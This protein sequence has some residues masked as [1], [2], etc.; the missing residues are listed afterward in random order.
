MTTTGPAIFFDGITSARHDVTVELAAAALI[1]RAADG[2]ALAQWPYNEIEPLSAPAGLLRIGR[3][4]ST[5]LARLDVIDQDLA[6]AIDQR[7]VPIDR[8]GAAERRGRRKV[9]F[10]SVAATASL[11]VMAIFGVPELATRLA[12]HIPLGVERR[13]GAAVDTQIRSM[14]D[15]KKA[16]ARFE[17]GNNDTEKAAR[18]AFE[19]LAGTLIVEADLAIPIRIAVLRKS[20]ANAITLPGGIVYVF[21]GLIDKSDTPDELAGV[22]AHEFGHVAHRDGTR[23]VLANAG[24]AFLFGTLLGDFLGGGAVLI[25]ARTVLQSS[26][27]RDV[28]AAAD[29]YA[30]D[31]MRKADGNQRALGTILERIAGGSHPIP[32]ILLDH[33]DTK[34]RVAAINSMARPAQAKAMLSNAE[35]AQVKRICAG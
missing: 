32:K 25:A 16:G 29:N 28:E 33:P 9:V 26:Y 18:V 6:A 4:G 21:S 3:A 20:D 5:T 23:H 17:C 15:D 1:I 31:L 34:D 30:V 8:T 22:I 10:W 14:L 35:W 24:M 12:P 13:L 27:S 11:V 19:K 7:S 2:R